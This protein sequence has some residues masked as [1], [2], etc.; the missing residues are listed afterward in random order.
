[1]PILTTDILYKYSDSQATVG[2]DAASP[3][4]T[5]N[6]DTQCL[7]GY[8]STTL[9]IAGANTLFG[10]LSGDQNTSNQVDYRCI[11]V[12]NAHASLILYDTY[13]WIDSLTVGGSDIAIGVDATIAK[14]ISSSSQQAAIIDSPFTAPSGV[15]FSSPSTKETGV[16]LGNIAPGYARAFWIRRS[17]TGGDPLAVDQLVIEV[18]G[19]SD[20]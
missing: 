8:I 5:S 7:G 20:A 15:T 19:S 4:T 9:W 6:L 18:E 13:L 2:D 14:I 1:M 3:T 12:H 11:F 17:A 16:F 10:N